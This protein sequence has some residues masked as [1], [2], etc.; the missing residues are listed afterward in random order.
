MT[1]TPDFHSFL[2]ESRSA[3]LDENPSPWLCAAAEVGDYTP[4]SICVGAVYFTDLEELRADRDLRLLLGRCLRTSGGLV[5]DLDP[6]PHPLPF[7]AAV[8]DLVNPLQTW[9]WPLS[10]DQAFEAYRWLVTTHD[11]HGDFASKMRAWG[12][13]FN[14]NEKV[15]DGVWGSG[16]SARCRISRIACSR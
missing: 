10:V 8:V 9:P 4:E 7:E 6:S 12:Y 3:K 14:K 15:R 13:L 11:E 5:R 1:A 2:V 16:R